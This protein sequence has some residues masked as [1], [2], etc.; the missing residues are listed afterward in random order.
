MTSNLLLLMLLFSSQLVDSTMIRCYKGL[1]YFVGQ[2]IYQDTE[3]CDNILGLGE[4]YCYTFYEESSVQ[5]V[6]KMGCSSIVCNV[7][8]SRANKR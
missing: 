1:K 7:S 5:S 4:S 8:L 3:D 6:T 2:D